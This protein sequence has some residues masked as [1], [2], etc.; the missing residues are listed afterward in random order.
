MNGWK[1]A[2]IGA[3][4]GIAIT[5]ALC[6]WWH[7]KH[8]IT[9]EVTRVDTLTVYNEIVREKP[10]FHERKVVDTMYMVLKD[11]VRMR[12]TLYVQLEREQKV[13]GD[14]LYTAWVSGHRP[15]LDSIRLRE[16]TQIVTI[17]TEVARPTS[18]WGVGLSAGYGVSIV[19]GNVRPSPYLGIG[20]TWR[21]FEF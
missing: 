10:V 15:A 12:D 5:A 18:R 2:G 4:A 3:A 7:V 20:L 1:A 16:R 9:H 17:E 21:I 11:T 8:P 13:Y 19:D 14:S 6:L